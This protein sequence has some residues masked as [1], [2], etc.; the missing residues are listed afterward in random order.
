LSSDEWAGR[1][2]LAQ[3][4]GDANAQ[5]VT[6]GLLESG[7]GI[8]GLKKPIGGFFKRA[9]AAF[10][11][12]GDM[13]R[14]EMADDLLTEEI[15]R[16]RSLDELRSSGDIKRIAEEASAATGYV[17]GKFSV[18][19]LLMFS[20]RFFD[21]RLR[22]ILRATRGLDLDAPLDLIPVVGGRL[23]KYVPKVNKYSR[24]QDRY[25][26]RMI[27]RTI[28]WGVFLT[29]ALN[30]MQGHKTDFRM[31]KDGKYN[32]NFVRFRAFNRDRSLF[33]PL[34]SMLRII[35][36]AGLGNVKDTVK[37]VFTNP[38]FSAATDYFVNEDFSGAPIRDPE[39]TP[40]EQAFQM[41]Q[42]QISIT[43]P[44]S[45]DEAG[46][47]LEKVIEAA[48]EGDPI[49]AGIGTLDFLSDHIGM[50]SSPLSKSEFE[51][52]LND[53]GLTLEQRTEIEQILKD[54]SQRYN[55][56]YR[57]GFEE[58]YEIP[59]DDRKGRLR[60]RRDNYEIDAK[61]FLKGRVTTLQ[62][63]KARGLVKTEFEKNNV[64]NSETS[65]DDLELYRKV[66]G[67]QFVKQMLQGLKKLPPLERLAPLERLVPL[68]GQPPTPSKGTGLEKLSSSP[69]DQWNQV[70]QVLDQGDLIALKK[71]WSG[72]TISRQ[73]TESLKIAF[74]KEPVGQTNFRKWSRQTL[75]QI[76][77]NAAN[78]R[79]QPEF[80]TV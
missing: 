64:I 6:S 59:G 71:I 74:K 3:V 77:T 18:A 70:S 52:L 75:R 55:R 34:D 41:L 43:Q 38:I 9:N 58:Y 47:S 31:V 28:G 48:S 4:S 5:D 21:A 46:E 50:K 20:A 26:R 56:F 29:V 32:S 35:V 1:Y 16:G 72:E 66:L 12:G 17:D 13:A 49:K 2:G 61:L 40:G 24:I 63:T 27:L 68:E 37:S 10:N 7:L 8:K 53:P 79:T 11:T 69:T 54:R 23:R 22:T 14:F 51:S 73:E 80:A 45:I 30:E 76:Q 57:K 15:A 62:T 42:Y 60:Y 25:A 39:G 33:G 65:P 44:F 19:N 78:V 67:G 36:N